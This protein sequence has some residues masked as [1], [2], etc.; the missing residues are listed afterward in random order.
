MNRVRQLV[1][2]TILFEYIN[3]TSW[4]ITRSTSLMLFMAWYLTSTLGLTRR[5][6][7]LACILHNRQYC[8]PL[9]RMAAQWV[10]TAKCNAKLRNTIYG[11]V[12]QEGMT[13]RTKKYDDNPEYLVGNRMLVVKKW[14]EAEKGV[15][16]IDYSH[17]FPVVLRRFDLDAIAE[18]Y[19]IVLEPSWVGLCTSEILGFLG[20]NYPVFV[21]TNEPADIRFIESLESNIHAI[22]IAANWWVDHR[23][24]RPLDDV[25]KDLDIAMIGSWAA[26]KR[27]YRVFESLGRLRQQGQRLKMVCIGYPAGWDLETIKA[28]AR[29]YEI[30]DQLS[31]HEWL[32]AD[33]V[34]E[35]VNRAKVSIVWSHKEGSNRAIIEGL[36]ADVPCILLSSFNYGYRYHHINSDTGIYARES[37][38]DQALLQSC[39]GQN[40]WRPRQWIMDHLT[41]QHATKIIDQHLEEYA[42]KNG[43][44][45][46]HGCACKI[47]GLHSMEY[48]SPEDVELHSEDHLWLKSQIRKVA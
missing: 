7:K 18:R 30:E 22:P 41:C 9:C 28:L 17:L 38:L 14:S 15:I 34:N 32:T 39:R 5:A 25:K 11:I 19:H 36:C 40:T 2:K 33:K 23:V 45:W 24:F 44:P 3:K 31:F 27:H 8:K 35:Q 21:Q 43:G 6:Y 37:E 20:R 1:I 4:L 42:R 16:I 46:T 29:H 12:S 47:S 13:G 26:Y 48:W 10:S